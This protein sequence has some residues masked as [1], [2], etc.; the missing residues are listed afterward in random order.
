MFGFG[1]YLLPK[2]I[3]RYCVKLTFPVYLRIMKRAKLFGYLFL[4]IWKLIQSALIADCQGVTTFPPVGVHEKN[5]TQIAFLNAT[6]VVSPNQRLTNATLWVENGIIK[7]VGSKI[8]IPSSVYT[9]DLKGRWIFP[10]F[11][12]PY[13]P[14]GNSDAKPADIK[15]PKY[16]NP[17]VSPENKVINY[18]S[19]AFP[20]I[21][22][23]RKNGFGAA[24]CVPDDGIF[25]GNGCF[26]LLQDGLTNSQVLKPEC[27]Q[28]L[29]FNK[30]KSPE[31]YPG[32]LMGAIALMRQT[33][34]D[35]SWY[36]DTWKVYQNNPKLPKPE[37]N[38]S[39]QQLQEFMAGTNPYVFQA[40]NTLEMLR[41][42]KISQEFDLKKL[43]CVGTPFDYEWAK[44][45]S[46]TKMAC[47]LPMNTPKPIYADNP[48][49]YLNVSLGQLRRWEQ[50][51][52][53]PV[54]LLAQDISI[55][56]T[57]NQLDKETTFWKQLYKFL[58]YGLTEE[59]ALAALTT[60]PARWFGVEKQLGTIEA[61]KIANFI[62]TSGNIFYQNATI[63]ET[64][65]QGNQT[66]IQSVPSIDP[67][68]TYVAI[69]GNSNVS[70]TISG[71]LSE[72][73][74]EIE[75]A[76]N[77]YKT[78]ITW[79]NP[80]L[81]IE[82]DDFPDRLNLAL[83]PEV[84]G[85]VGVRYIQTKPS[86]ISFTKQKSFQDTL[87]KPVTVIPNAVSSPITFP[88]KAYG[89]TVYP[90]SESLLFKNATVWSNTEKGIL[91]ETDVFIAQGK[92]QKVGKNLSIPG[93]KVVE[94][95]GKHLTNGIIDEH[96]HIAI[97]G[98]VN[99][100]TQS[101]TAEVR[102]GDV[103]DPTDI[104]IYRQLSG[105]VTTSQLL[106]GS[107]N[108]IGG[109]A[110]L[111]KLRWGKTPEEYKIEQAPLFIKFAL[112]ENVKQ[113]NWG[114][115]YSVRYPQTRLGVEQIFRDA[116]QTA[117]EYEK[118]LLSNNT[119]NSY[120]VRR[121][122]ELDAIVEILQKKRFITCHSY[123]QS[124]ILTL[125]R[126]AESFGFQVNTF[127][128]ILE[129]YKIA[130]EMK[131]HGVNASTFSDWWAY[132]YEVIDAIPQNAALLLRKGIATAINSDD[133]EM[134]RRLNQEAAKSIKYAGL[135]KEESWKMVTYYPAKMLHL[136]NKLGTIEPG[137]DAD[138]VIWS[139][140]PL[141]IYAIA[142]QTYVDGALLYDAQESRKQ[143]D[144][145]EQERIQ[146]IEKMRKSAQ[147]NGST[148]P[149]EEIKEE[150]SCGGHG[151]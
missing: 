79:Q 12:E 66:I 28:N 71:T 51:P 85:L 127:T 147:T 86:P 38:L 7:A 108:C 4:F 95:S 6:I 37:F 90:L 30:G 132:K 14:V 151:H 124:E 9:V 137:K 59:Q 145:I 56:F 125:M 93:A 45:I 36:R 46:A 17:A 113:S 118:N 129:G 114:D 103:I 135:S 13:Y 10:A 78:K 77:K 8:P 20:A 62:I 54:Y 119:L 142:E 128:H 27:S 133:P 35:A 120:P 23:L 31:D 41:M 100:G 18:L 5:P 148:L 42:A 89:R 25:R 110:A 146:L 112:G 107:A 140:E 141:S 150:Y 72:P 117:K 111:V 64:W 2:K 115:K 116:F 139:Q 80:T 143:S 130:N 122:L 96:S 15:P 109:Q 138:L 69:L 134:G 24:H 47:I 123:V 99:E 74:A 83:S 105:G 50:S 91:T 73:K 131:K 94:A 34:L 104:N 32:S 33:F 22:D 68:G 92:I 48:L 87:L 53:N 39:L 40:Q 121:D 1:S 75:Q 82:S 76:G 70:L 67:R 3:Y 102:I 144:A 44:P 60:Q 136:D 61:G 106:H 98:G 52:K 126:V 63:L 29:S 19:K 26:V 43:I 81:K 97:T 21:Y 149:T 65:V 58:E 101:V 16:W 88:N 49:D 11:I 84:N 57:T 55:S